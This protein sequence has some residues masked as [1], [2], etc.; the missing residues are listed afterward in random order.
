MQKLPEY[1]AEENFNQAEIQKLLET[2]DLTDARDS[3][4]NITF[5]M[6]AVTPTSRLQDTSRNVIFIC[7]LCSRFQNSKNPKIS[8]TREHTKIQVLLVRLWH[9][10]VSAPSA[11]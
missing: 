1:I 2:G 8:V 7:R 11:R 10:S 3:Y 9:S 6:D 5:S 4:D